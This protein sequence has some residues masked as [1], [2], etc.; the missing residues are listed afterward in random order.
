MTYTFQDFQRDY[1]DA[2]AC[3]HKLFTMRFP[4]PKCPKCGE[5][6]KYHKRNTRPA[7]ICQCGEHEISPKKGHC[8]KAS[9]GDR[10]GLRPDG[11]N[12]L[13]IRVI[14]PAKRA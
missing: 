5:V 11:R 1:P 2:D 14:S 7:Y 12:S 4:N 3:L 8:S 13:A 6:N 9:A 10:R